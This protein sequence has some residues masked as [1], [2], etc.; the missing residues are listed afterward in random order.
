[1]L[2]G[3]LGGFTE[4]LA[5]L[6]LIY[7]AL[8][9]LLGF[10]VGVL[11]GLSRGT[12][13]AITLPLTFYLPPV[14]AIS[15]LIGIA[16]G[17]ATGGAVT[18]ILLNTPGEPSSAATCLD[19]YP[20]ARQ[21]KAGKAL[22]VALV[23]S[24]TGDILATLLLIAIAQPL[25]SVALKIGPF[26]LA[27]IMLFAMTF[28]AGLSGK[29]LR[30]GLIAAAAGVLL[31]TVG[32]DVEAGTPRLAFGVTEIYDGIPLLAVAIGTLALAEMLHQIERPE[33]QMHVE[34]V[35]AKDKD[36]GRM[37]WTDLR[38]VSPH[39]G[40]A[41]LIGIVIGIL[42]GIGGSVASF[43]SYAAARQSSKNPELFGSGA[44]EGV[45][46]A[47]TADN[48]AVPAGLVPL[49]ALGIPG[50]NVAALLIGAFVIHGIQPGPR[51]FETHAAV[52]AGIYASMIVASALMLALGWVLLRPMVKL[53][54]VPEQ[55]IV[56]LV[57][58]LCVMGAFLEG[59]GMTTIYLMLGLGVLGYLMRK[60]AFPIVPFIV[61]FVLAPGLERSLRQSV[62]LSNGEPAVLLSHPIALAFLLLAVLSG[63]YMTRMQARLNRLSGTE[64]A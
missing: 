60:L 12:T 50:T 27:A 6:N 47:E 43:M 59:G 34:A 46:A 45:A 23:G 20:L 48:A 13:V 24:V 40:R 41:S 15:F 30:N 42:P 19:G 31:A 21:G 22:K 55:L 38:C 2:T 39:M 25:A 61:G 35:D 64:A 49:F 36:S 56:P 26:E 33:R 11:P 52:V 53:A 28:I 37:T 17:G 57:L 32:L 16:K 54:E 10:A 51:M 8:G 9:L 18:S 4:A 29:S 5:P 14:T 62:A 63:W 1:M 58:C 3:L 7:I 44:I